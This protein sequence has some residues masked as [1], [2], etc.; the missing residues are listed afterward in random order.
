MITGAV[1]IDQVDEYTSPS[2]VRIDNLRSFAKTVTNADGYYSI[3]VMVGDTIQFSSSYLVPRKIVIS[4]NLYDKGVLQAHLDVETI[5]LSEA[6]IGGLDKNL[7]NNL[8][9]RRDIKGEIYN[10]IGLDQRLRDLEPK[11]DISKFRATDI[12]NPVR[13]IGHVNG[14]Y[15]KQRKIQLFE[16]NQNILNEVINYFPDEFFINDLK[17]PDYKV[18][19]F[20][21]YAD[22]KINIKSRVM[23]R[24]FE[25]IGLE[26]EPVAEMYLKELNQS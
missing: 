26:L 4:Q 14:H 10:Q 17:I 1:I 11:K 20:L 25:L 12:M 19:E 13:L 2:N 7:R 21:Q 18:H 24:Q 16:R 9:Y 6:L 22:K 5:E 15:K 8:H 3:P 23:N